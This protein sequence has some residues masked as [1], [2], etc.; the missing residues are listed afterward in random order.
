MNTFGNEISK[1]RLTEPGVKYFL[2]QTLQHCH[3][4]KEKHYNMLFNIGCVIFFFIIL[5]IILLYKYKGKLTSEQ[6]KER[7]LN[8]KKYILSKIKNY[9]DAKIKS[10]QSLIT[11]L[12]TWENEFDII[13]DTPLKRFS[14][15]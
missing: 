4:F 8:K 5:A 15:S 7:E 6:I 3:T 2:N 14:K 1:P 9:Q 11:G 10:Q 13:N 12:P